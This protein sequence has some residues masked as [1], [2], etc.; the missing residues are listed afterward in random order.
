MSQQVSVSRE[1]LKQIGSLF[2]AA[3]KLMQDITQFETDDDNKFLE[4]EILSQMSTDSLTLL[5]AAFKPSL[6]VIF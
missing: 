3:S 5:Q 6:D 4:T 1:T 2:T